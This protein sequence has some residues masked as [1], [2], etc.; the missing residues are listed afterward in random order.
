M[1]KGY[2]ILAVILLFIFPPIG[3]IMIIAGFFL[4]P[5][6]KPVQKTAVKPK[7]HREKCDEWFPGLI[8]TIYEAEKFFKEH[9]DVTRKNGIDIGGVRVVA[10]PEISCY[11]VIIESLDD[12]ICSD[13]WQEYL[14]GWNIG[15]ANKG[16]FGYYSKN[17]GGGILYKDIRSNISVSSDYPDY[18]PGLLE[19][20][21]SNWTECGDRIKFKNYNDY[22]HSV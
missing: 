16:E 3:L 21:D 17:F 15:H 18:V 5:E 12:E 2:W 9:R 4:K 6:K 14:P 13:D 20:V 8:E 11:R 22:Y 19:E 1:S 10:K 7:S